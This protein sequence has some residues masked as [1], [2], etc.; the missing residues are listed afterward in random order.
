[1]SIGG[2]GGL[3]ERKCAGQSLG[4]RGPTKNPKKPTKLQ[5]EPPFNIKF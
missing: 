2:K 3:I 5:V 4:K 1:M